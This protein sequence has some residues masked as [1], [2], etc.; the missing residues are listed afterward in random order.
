MIEGSETRAPDRWGAGG[1]L[2][3]LVVGVLGLIVLVAG[4][5]FAISGLGSS[6]PES[7]EA[8]VDELL[9]AVADEDVLGVLA[10]LDPHE[11]DALRGPVEDLAGELQRLDVLDDSF[12]LSGVPGIDVEFSD[13]VYRTEE[14]REGLVRVHL[15][16]GTVSVDVDADEIP[17]GDVVADTVERLAGEAFVDTSEMDDLDDDAFLVARDTEDG[18]RVSIGYTLAEAARM[19]DGEPDL[20]PPLIAVGAESPEAAVGEMLESIAALD[21][22]GAIARLSPLEFA[23]LHEY[24]SVVFTESESE[25]TELGRGIGITIDDLG[26]RSESSGD[27]ASVFVETFAITVTADD[28]R[29]SIAYDGACFSV[30]GGLSALGLDEALFG[31][32]ADQ[33]CL[34]ELTGASDAFGGGF[35]DSDA[36][37]VGITTALVD[38]EWYVAPVATV[39]DAVVAGVRSLDRTDLEFFLDIIDG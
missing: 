38:G 33:L 30:D 24:A 39:L 19:A 16:G 2:G 17:I 14:V 32:G 13:I 6:G 27:R 10:A 21:L 8:A 18:W 7:P 28:E 5:I 3:R 26:L 29:L 34:D 4:V 1:R 23:P 9:A 15:A 25:L 36:P 22:H 35:S 12:E 20:G 11:R 31:F 37:E